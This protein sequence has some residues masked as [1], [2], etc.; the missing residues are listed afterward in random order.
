M[1]VEARI[2]PRGNAEAVK[3]KD[4]LTESIGVIMNSSKTSL[5]PDDMP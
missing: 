5:N 4:S 3:S 2:F 1:I